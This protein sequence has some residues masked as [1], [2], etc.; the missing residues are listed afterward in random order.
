MLIVT[1][2]IH[3]DQ[4]HLALCVRDLD[5][6]AAAARQRAGNIA[7]DFGV[8]TDQN[9]GRLLI[10]ERWSDQSALS[11]HLDAMDTKAFV[12]EWRD[13]MQGDIRKYDAANERGLMDP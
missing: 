7:Y 12:R 1:G 4:L 11:A 9:A 13:R 8:A 3:V 10:A 5:V 6:L 2:H